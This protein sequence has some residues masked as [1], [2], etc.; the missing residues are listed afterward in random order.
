LQ[1]E[2]VLREKIAEDETVFVRRIIVQGVTL[3]NRARLKETIAPLL[4]KRL[5]KKEIKQIIELLGRLPLREFSLTTNGTGL[6]RL[7]EQLK[8]TGKW[9]KF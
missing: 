7:A 2:R 5:K 6:D 9:L 3:L 1:E 8:K 4:K